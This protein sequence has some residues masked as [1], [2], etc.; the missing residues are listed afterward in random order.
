[1][2]EAFERQ[3]AAVDRT[4][5]VD[6][7]YEDLVR[8]PI[9]RLRA[10]YEA[11]NLGEFE[12]IRPIFE[13]YFADRR[14]YRTNTYRRDPAIEAE[15]DR[16]WGP[17]MRRYGYMVGTDGLESAAETPETPELPAEPRPS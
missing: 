15:V 6:V 12:R 16:R 14:D 4:R 8:D 3:R 1:M 5:I 9:G 10:I 17:Y 11:L 13:R 7:T 2:Y